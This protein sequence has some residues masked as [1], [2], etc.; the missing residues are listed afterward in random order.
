MIRAARMALDAVAVA[1]F[2]ILVLTFAG[3]MPNVGFPS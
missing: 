3:Y 2:L 1:A